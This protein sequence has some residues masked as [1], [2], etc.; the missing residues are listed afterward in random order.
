[1]CWLSISRPKIIRAE[2]AYQEQ[3]IALWQCSSRWKKWEQKWIVT[4]PGK[5]AINSI[6]SHKIQTN[7]ISAC[8]WYVLILLKIS[9][10]FKNGMKV[11]EHFFSLLSLLF[12]SWKQNYKII[13][14][15]TIK[16]FNFE[17]DGFERI[18]NS[19]MIH[20][21]GLL[22]LPIPVLCHFISPAPRCIWGQGDHY[23]LIF[24][25]YWD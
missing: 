15:K 21:L 13:L 22:L 25:P 24:S 2:A 19:R 3:T 20:R 12:D 16:Y 1:M 14:Q 23:F 8:Y 17:K 11:E 18:W 10:H 9:Q 5:Q 7:P 4:V 6:L